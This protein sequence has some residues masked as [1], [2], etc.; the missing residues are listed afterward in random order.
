MQ[1][2]IQ[3][4]S[5]RVVTDSGLTQSLELPRCV[6]TSIPISMRQQLIFLP[7]GTTDVHVTLVCSVVYCIM[8]SFISPW[9]V[10]T[11]AMSCDMP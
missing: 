8:I 6:H 5:P 4:D 7:A 11:H 3:W 2:R 9:Q 10:V 1:A